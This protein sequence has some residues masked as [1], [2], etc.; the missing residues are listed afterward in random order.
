[1]GALCLGIQGWAVHENNDHWQTLV[2]TT[3]CFC[4][5]AHV[6]AIKTEDSFLY[7]EGFF[8]NMFLLGSVLL[9]FLLQMAIIYLPSLNAVFSTQPLTLKELLL[10]IGAGVIVFHAVELEKFIRHRKKKLRLH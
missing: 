6:L 1:M 8:N 2:F 9:T 3:L 5:M 4:Q 7:R 10:C